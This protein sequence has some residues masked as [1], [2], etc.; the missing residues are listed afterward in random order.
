MGTEASFHADDAPWKRIKRFLQCEA[1]DLS[2]QYNLAGSVKADQVKH[3]LADVDTDDSEVFKASLFLGTHCPCCTVD[4][5]S[6]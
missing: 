6:G 1:L 5:G 2:S 4:P 3:V